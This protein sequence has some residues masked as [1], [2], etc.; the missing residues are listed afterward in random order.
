MLESWTEI[1]TAL[2]AII[3]LGISIYNIWYTQF[4]DEPLRF[5]INK[6]TLLGLEVKRK[7]G[8]FI[9]AAFLLNVS[10]N[11]QSNKTKIVRD[12]VL[13]VKDNKGNVFL[14]NPVALFDFQYYSSNLGSAN[15]LKAQKGLV[16]LP[17]EIPPKSNYKFDDY[18]LMLPFNKKTSFSLQDQPLNIDVFV[19]EKEDEYYKVTEQFIENEDLKKLKNGSFN[20]IES[21]SIVDSRKKFEDKSFKKS[22]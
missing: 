2:V 18:L 20:A 7:T 10:V 9:S 6:W 14:Y 21:S 13:K 16:P 11:N 22:T 8:N 3:A 4:R 1:V 12:I 19:S 15:M 17:V 5:V